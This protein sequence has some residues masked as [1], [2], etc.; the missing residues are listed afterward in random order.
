MTEY[1]N[2]KHANHIRDYLGQEKGNIKNDWRNRPIIM[3][4]LDAA[5]MKDSISIMDTKVKSLMGK[6]DGKLNNW[7]LSGDRSFYAIT[8][9]RY[10]MDYLK[11]KNQ[12][13][14][15]NFSK[16][17]GPDGI[18]HCGKEDIGI[19]V[20]TVNG[21]IA[22]A[23]FIERMCMYLKEKAYDFSG[24]YEISYD[25]ERLNNEIK[26]SDNN[27][28]YD[29]IAKVGSN[30]ILGAS[31]ELRKLKVTWKI[32]NRNAGCIVWEKNAANRFPVLE[33]LTCRVISALQNT[34][35]SQLSRMQKNIVF[36]G[37]NHCGPENWLNP[38]IFQ[39]MANGGIFCKCQ[40]DY[41]QDYLLRNLPTSVLGLCYYI[42]SLDR[43]EP[44]YSPLKMF[45]RDTKNRIN[46]NL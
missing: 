38:R 22:D 19:E 4:W 6:K 27:A 3:D 11:S 29:Y 10:I 32:T 5:S 9:E 2:H 7:F 18:L 20:T 44:Y 37:V 28:F 41:I 35:S 1:C 16:Q 23:I 8:A 46:I 24:T 21:F 15:D 40:I 17:G 30:V 31:D 25:Y 33:H 45:W 34:K 36:I 26:K 42:Y 39:E 14:S 13:L 43:D 12:N